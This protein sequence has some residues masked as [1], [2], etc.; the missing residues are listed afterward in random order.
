M[1][2]TF[3]RKRS[4]SL[5]SRYRCLL[6]FAVLL[7]A[8][9]SGVTA[10]RAEAPIFDW[11]EVEGGTVEVEVEVDGIWKSPT[12]LT[13]NKDETQRY[14]LRLTKPL[15]AGEEGWWVRVHVNGAVR[16][17][18]VYP[19]NPE[20]NRRR[21]PESIT[22]PSSV[23]CRQSDGSSARVT[24]NPVNVR[25]KVKVQCES[26]WRGVTITAYKDVETPIT[27]THDVL[28]KQ[29]ECP[30][31]LKGLG[32]VS[33]SSN[34]NPDPNPNP[35]PNGESQSEMAATVRIPTRIPIRIRNPNPRTVVIRIPT[36]TT[37]TI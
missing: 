25:T 2:M 7:P 14:R 34:A 37:A 11:E 20:P 29:A 36:R 13:L 10:A 33:V 3:T 32:T 9:L 21:Q 4:L 26:K 6:T 12:P 30:P 28:D 23:G 16:I 24:G 31:D 17:D 18:G 19:D 27:I 15:P 8:L 35:N 5:G 22:F 1:M